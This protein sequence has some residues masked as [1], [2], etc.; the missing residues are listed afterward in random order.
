MS[1]LRKKQYRFRLWFTLLTCFVTVGVVSCYCILQVSEQRYQVDASDHLLTIANLI[2][3]QVDPEKHEALQSVE[4]TNTAL[5]QEQLAPLSRA[6]ALIPDIH[7]I[8]TLRNVRNGMVFVLDP[9]PAGD[10]DHKGMED[11]SALMSE[12]K[13]GTVT[14]HKV[15]STGYAQVEPEF[16]RDQ[17]GTFLSAYAPI[18]DRHGKVIAILGVGQDAKL[19]VAHIEQL[20]KTAEATLLLV[21]VL[22]GIFAIHL[23]KRDISALGTGSKLRINFPK[24]N[25]VRRSILEGGLVVLVGALMVAGASAFVVLRGTQSELSSSFDRSQLL[26]S[27]DAKCKSLLAAESLDRSEVTSL[28]NQVSLSQLEGISAPSPTQ[29]QL[30]SAVEQVSERVRTEAN[31]EREGEQLLQSRINDQNDVLIAV[32]LMASLLS[33]GSLVILRSA[34]RRETD[35]DQ[36]RQE[37]LRHQELYQHVADNLPIGFFTLAECEFNFTNPSWNRIMS[38]HEGETPWTAFLRT[39][40][41]DDAEVVLN[42]LTEAQDRGKSCSITYRLRFEPEDLRYVEVQAVP[43]H[44]GDGQFTHLVGFLIDVTAQANSH[45][46]LEGKNEEIE[47]SNFMLRQALRVLEDNFEAMVHSLVKVVEA[48]DPYTAGHSERV[49]G[50][51][52]RIAEALGLDEPSVRIVKMGSLIHDIGKIGVPDVILTKPGRLTE[53]E[54]TL[55]KQH[56]IIGARMVESIPSFQPCMPIV[57]SHH[58]RLDGKGYPYGLAGNQI[59]TFVRIVTV[60]DCFDAMTSNRAYR[61]GLSCEYALAELRKEVESG[62]LDGKIV[63][64]LA[65]IVLKGGLLWSEPTIQAA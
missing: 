4:Q 52:V 17:W 39:I 37:S 47:A 56:P 42:T 7:Y 8:Y 49:M 30:E 59:G 63:E 27:L 22:G 64:A 41:P 53:N 14:M 23:T 26:A 6:K 54:F 51:S 1:E 62:G 57:M 10:A 45:R 25:L 19:I 43:V 61:H 36:A 18:F 11:K 34:S 2:A 24:G 38:L 58:E 29:A 13:D 12:Y 44:N 5:Y 60:A 20:R 33:L 40:H 31:T 35:I 28:A 48:K 16:S 15:F 3:L 46:V 65:D 32:F 50:Y 55:V 21:L 9:S